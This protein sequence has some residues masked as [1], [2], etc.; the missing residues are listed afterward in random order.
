MSLLP[1]TQE[2][3]HKMLGMWCLMLALPAWVLEVS[4][5]LWQSKFA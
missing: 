3:Y 2:S 1:S 4:C 5:A